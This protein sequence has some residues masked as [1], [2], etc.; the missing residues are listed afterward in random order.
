MP[1]IG[2]SNTTGSP[3]SGFPVVLLVTVPV[4]VAACKRLPAR[5][6]PKAIK[7]E[8][9]EGVDDEIRTANDFIR[10]LQSSR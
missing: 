2:A 5:R 8:V 3:L 6:A 4:M 1:V 7:K 10:F 9:R